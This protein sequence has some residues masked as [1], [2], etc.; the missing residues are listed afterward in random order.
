[1]CMRTTPMVLLLFLALSR[2]NPAA[3][4]ELKGTAEQRL[5]K[6]IKFLSS[7]ALEGRGVGTEGL[8]KAAE[9]VR[10]GFADAGL[11]TDVV[12][13][14]AYQKFQMVT[15]VELG[16]GNSLTFSGP[17]GKTIDLELGV[18]FNICSFGGSGK[19]DHTVV[20]AGY[21]INAK[22]IPYVDLA[23]VDVK[24]RVVIVMRRNPQ[25]GNPESPFSVGSGISRHAE[26][27]T[28]MSVCASAGAAAVLFVNDP[29]TVQSQLEKSIEQANSRIVKAA[30]VLSSLKDSDPGRSDAAKK[31]KAGIQ[32]LDKIIGDAH[33]PDAGDELMKFGYAGNG[34][35]RT[36]PAA[37]ISIRKCNE[38][39]EQ[40]LDTSLEK[41]EGTIDVRLEPQSQVLKDWKLVGQA[42]VKR[43]RTE[44]K[45]VIAVLEGEG[46]L[47]DETIVV[48]AHYDHVGRGGNG[49]RAPG[50]TEIHN[51]ADDN[52]S[53]TV[54]LIELARRLAARKT[55]LPRRIVFIAFTAEELGLIGSEKYVDQ[56]VFPIKNTIAMYNMDMVGRL[57]KKLTVFGIG[58]SP[59]F[60]D[61]V[62][63]FAESAEL[64]LILKP[65]G[66]GP[67]DHSSFYA[68]K[69]PVLHFFTGTHSDYHRPG[70]DWE[71]INLGG[72]RQVVGL[73]EQMVVKTAMT[74]KRPAYLEVKSRAQISRSGSR[75]YF[76]SI[77]NFGSEQPGYAISGTASGSPASKSGLKAGDHI[78]EFG[79][80]KITDLNDFDL[81][82]RDYSP[83][84]EVPFVVQRD[85]KNVKLTVTLDKPR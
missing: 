51:G 37:H 13:G 28:K 65:D 22:G 79:T 20:F 45:N 44:V 52:A 3:A 48:G 17:D 4:V 27:R 67:S 29:H 80:H 54:A 83:G 11:T 72:I 84:E 85:G 15:G 5:L 19:I 38:L 6:D 68:R 23:G 35:D 77:P 47:A 33:A 16:S 50:S 53:G 60:K 69:I 55:A 63:R 36:I 34:K 32:N 24:D 56:P 73:I 61:D 12:D 81:A 31:L 26:L 43:I 49:S 9:Y 7:D 39:L 82:L 30:R 57:E 8:N 71:K 41:I 40:A 14:D 1:M 70:D 25:Q 58:T 62:T 59:A 78:I 42:S 74:E 21:G 75:P 64:E 18:D 66:F 76:G 46:P 2:L 10:S